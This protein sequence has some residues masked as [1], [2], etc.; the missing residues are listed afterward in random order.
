MRFAAVDTWI[1]VRASLTVVSGGNGGIRLGIA[2]AL[3]TV[4]AVMFFTMWTTTDGADNAGKNTRCLRVTPSTAMQAKRNTDM[5]LGSA[6]DA[7]RAL[8]KE[9]VPIEGL[10]LGPSLR[11]PDV[12]VNGA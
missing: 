12:K 7:W 10:G 4:R 2:L 5:K 6:N 1:T 9:R 8:N 3:R 11:I